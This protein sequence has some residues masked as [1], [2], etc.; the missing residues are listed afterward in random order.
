MYKMKKIIFKRKM[1]NYNNNI[2]K[3]KIINL[4]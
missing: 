3:L 1:K 2:K 4:D